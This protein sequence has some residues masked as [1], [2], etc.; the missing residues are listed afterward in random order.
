MK[1]PQPDSECTIAASHNHGSQAI[2]PYIPPPDTSL[3]FHIMRDVN[4][5]RCTDW[6]GHGCKYGGED[7]REPD[8]VYGY[9]VLVVFGFDSN[10][11]GKL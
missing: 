1:A 3:W 9:A 6:V 2:I 10:G 11:E 7:A 8:L 5:Q 4:S